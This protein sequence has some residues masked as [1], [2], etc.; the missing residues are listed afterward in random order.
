[1][2][3]AVKRFIDIVDWRGSHWGLFLDEESEPPVL[4]VD[5]LQMPK[6]TGQV[7]LAGEAARDWNAVPFADFLT[8]HLK[9]VVSRTESG[10]I[11]HDLG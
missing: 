10:I 2:V 3:R 8:R 4:H 6:A 9:Q 11:V 1:M 7:T 5:E